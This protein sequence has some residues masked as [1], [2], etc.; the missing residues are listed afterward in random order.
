[1]VRT[2]IDFMLKGH[3]G[4]AKTIFVTSTKAQEGKSHTSVN[5]ATSISYSE[6][7]V[8]L[9]ETD[10]RVPKLEDYLGVKNNKG[11]TDY[12]S[13]PKI[14]LESVTFKAKDNPYLDVIPSG[15]IPPNP[16][17]LMMS[18][19]V[20]NVFNSAKE[21]YDYVIVDTAAVGLV[22]ETLLISDFADM[23]V[24]V[25]SAENLDKRQL[26]V[27]RNM[28]DEKRLP[29]MTILLNGTKRRS[30][31]GYGYGYGSAPKKKWYQF[32]KA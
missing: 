13:D 1:M 16:A 28:Y 11:F 22:T 14:K 29:N 24:Y 5:L 15:T 23:F 7:K 19:R 2:N 10:I 4:G 12:V 20:K 8:L 18:D 3:A 27:A 31:Y 30:G 25:V 21:K 9:I 32:K 17:E 6:K 26:H